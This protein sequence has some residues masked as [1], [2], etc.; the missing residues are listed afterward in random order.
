ME[1]LQAWTRQHRQVVKEILETGVY[2]VKEDYI[3]IKNDA[4]TEYYLELYRWYGNQAARLV[5]RPEGV[6]YPIW[7]FLK[8]E[9]K[10]PAITDTAVLTL[11]IPRDQ[12]VI[13]EVE[14]WGYRVNYMYIPLNAED[15]RAHE[16][17]LQRYGIVNETALIQTSKGNFYPLLKRKIINSWQ[18][19]FEPPRTNALVVTQGTVWELRREWL[20]EVEYGA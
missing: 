5:T 19:L 14:R 16:A 3:R 17:E 6:V 12:M 13:T 9:E 2:R 20:Q 11:S 8:E 7:L 10:L 4:I 18:R 1:M 15:E